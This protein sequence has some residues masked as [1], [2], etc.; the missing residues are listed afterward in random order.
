[1]TGKPEQ[2]DAAPALASVPAF[3]DPPMP[4]QNRNCTLCG[5]L[6]DRQNSLP[7]S[8]S[9]TPAEWVSYGQSIGIEPGDGQALAMWK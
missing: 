4:S 1:M 5:A 6:W 8:C 3:L 2:K 9:H 7:P